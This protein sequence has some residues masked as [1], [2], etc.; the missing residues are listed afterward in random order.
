MKIVLE[1]LSHDCSRLFQEPATIVR[2]N[3]QYN[4]AIVPTISTD[5]H[6]YFVS[7]SG[8]PK[9]SLSLVSAV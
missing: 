3:L 2:Q 8:G 5:L 1:I 4:L 9:G 6:A 7:F